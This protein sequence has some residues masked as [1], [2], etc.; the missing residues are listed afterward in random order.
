M[1]TLDFLENKFS[2]LKV[3]IRSFTHGI[4]AADSNSE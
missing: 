2:N 4:Q 3:G 1:T